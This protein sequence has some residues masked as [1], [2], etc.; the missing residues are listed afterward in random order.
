MSFF[1]TIIASAVFFILGVC[2]GGYVERRRWMITRHRGIVGYTRNVVDGV[3]Y[4][5]V[6]EDEWISRGKGVGLDARKE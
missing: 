6:T 4:I 3:P 5:V 1:T 2:F